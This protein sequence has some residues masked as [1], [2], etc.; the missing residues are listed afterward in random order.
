[1]IIRR[2]TI[3]DA[4]SAARVFTASFASMNFLPKIHTSDEDRAFVRHL[5]A[6]KEV[7]VAEHGDQILGI[8]CW[9]NGW[10]EQLY[11]DPAHHNGGTGT[12]LLARV[13]K[14]HAEGF[15]LWTFQAN[16]G[17]RRFY[18]RHGFTAVEFT[19]GA[20]NEENTPDVRYVWPLRNGVSAK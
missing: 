9:H 12:A 18:E 20:H 19:D 7:W 17:A 8:A 3:A 16:A 13:M 14:E 6:D 2:A 15:Q 1:M 11:V 5:I 10:L 4:E